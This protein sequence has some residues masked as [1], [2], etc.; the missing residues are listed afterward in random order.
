[1]RRSGCSGVLAP[2]IV[3]F[4]ALAP[5][6]AHAQVNIDQDKT[7]AHIF[8]SDCA[9]CHKSIRGL[10]NGR[11]S[12]ALTGFLA[13]HYTSSRE[14]AA[15]LAAYVLAGG[16]GRR[17]CGTSARGKAAAGARSGRGRGAQDTDRGTSDRQS[18]RKSRPQAPSRS[19]LRANG[20]N[21]KGWS[22]VPPRSLAA[23]APN[24]SRRESGASRTRQRGRHGRPKPA[25]AVPPKP[26]PQRLQLRQHLPSRQSPR[27][28]RRNQLR[29][30]LRR[31]N[32]S[33]TRLR[34]R[35][36][37]ISRTDQLSV[38]AG[39]GGRFLAFPC[40]P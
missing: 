27:S 35:R 19:G 22:G 9:V 18:R 24:E 10:A 15:A 28:A 17:D 34:R 12:S 6:M 21:P 5:P 8:A 16:G 36:L 3:L 32:R 33:R 14:E 29:A 23:S 40:A 2:A 39:F 30:P 11:G 25:E 20:A 38:A 13:E 26:S 4:A 37:T 7:P 31:S 1:M